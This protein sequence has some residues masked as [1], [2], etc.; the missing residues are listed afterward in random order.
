MMSSSNDFI[1]DAGEESGDLGSVV[2]RGWIMLVV[3][4]VG[5]ASAGG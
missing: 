1:A 5:D 2:R 3:P 4:S